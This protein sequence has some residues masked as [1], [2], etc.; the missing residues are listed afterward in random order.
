MTL[1]ICT[2]YFLIGPFFSFQTPTTTSCIEHLELLEHLN[3]KYSQL[4]QDLQILL[5]EKQDLIKQRDIYYD[6]MSRLNIQI[7]NLLNI[8]NQNIDFDAIVMENKYL[9]QRL[10]D[11]LNEKKLWSKTVSKYKTMLNN[12]CQST[13]KNKSKM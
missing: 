10:E 3:R 9:K 4:E 5:D 8:S 2:V 12:N 11:V 7:K 1:K 13:G 6:K